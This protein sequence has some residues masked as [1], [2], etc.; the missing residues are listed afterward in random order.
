MENDNRTPEEKFTNIATMLR[1]FYYEKNGLD[2]TID[3]LNFI[4]A[5]LKKIKTEKTEI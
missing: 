2:D 3:F 5:E 4:L 1:E